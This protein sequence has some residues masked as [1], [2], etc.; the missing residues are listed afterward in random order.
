MP[1]G[2]AHG[3]FDAVGLAVRPA[4]RVAQVQALRPDLIAQVFQA[5]P[6]G[7]R[8]RIAGKAIGGSV[9]LHGI[10]GEDGILPVQDIGHGP[11]CVAGNVVNGDGHVTAEGEGFPALQQHCRFHL[12]RDHG[13]RRPRLVLGS[14]G[15]LEVTAAAVHVVLHVYLPGPQQGASAA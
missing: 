7:V 5:G 12:A 3:Q 14:A 11:R 4:V 13:L 9:D 10:S 6:V 1:A 15:I 8:I 2:P